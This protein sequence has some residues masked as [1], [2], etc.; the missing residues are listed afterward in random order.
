MECFLWSRRQAPAVR[1]AGARELSVALPPE[2][3]R[4]WCPQYQ[5]ELCIIALL[6]SSPSTTRVRL[7]IPSTINSNVYLT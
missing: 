6:S 3:A 7:G 5:P 2:L 1:N 4:T